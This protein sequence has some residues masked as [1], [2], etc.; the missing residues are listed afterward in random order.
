MLT[1]ARMLG[2]LSIGWFGGIPPL[3]VD[4]ATV[5]LAVLGGHVAINPPEKGNVRL[6]AFYISSFVL[7]AAIAVGANIW[8]RSLESGKQD[9]LQQNETDARNQFAKSLKS[10]QNSNELILNFVANP[11]KGMTQ[12]Q[13]Q[14]IV[15]GFVQEQ[16]SNSPGI[17]K[18]L[19]RILS[20]AT[21]QEMR[22]WNDSWNIE[23]NSLWFKINAI[24]A[25]PK[26]AKSEQGKA[27]LLSWRKERENLNNIYSLRI[28]PTMKN[29]ALIEEQLLEGQTNTDEDK[30]SEDIFT[31]VLAGQPIS[32]GEMNDVTSY[33]N[34]LVRK[35]FPS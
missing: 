23:D 30:K 2:I 24:S 18:G 17:P 12:D 16:Q 31:K 25:N 3:L 7:L 21:V 5:S 35:N 22:Q 27:Q 6:R 32:W 13:V 33:M 15:K 8:Q 4:L 9:R 1:V 29:G 19:L 26:Q 10:V 11:P 14:L 28:L 34:R 20:L